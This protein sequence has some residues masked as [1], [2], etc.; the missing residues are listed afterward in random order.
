MP[1]FVEG[2]CQEYARMWWASERASLPPMPAYS[3][4]EKIRREALLDRFQ[5]ALTEERKRP[6]R[7]EADRAAT[8]DRLV[9]AFHRYLRPALDLSDRHGEF[10]LSRGLLE[11]GTAFNHKARRF[12]RGLSSEDVFQAGRNALVMHSIQALLGLPAEVTPAV[13]GYSLLYPYTDNYLDDPTVSGRDKAA[14]NERLARRLAG[15]GP[16]PEGA[17]ERAVWDAVSLIEGQYERKSFPQ[18]FASLQAIHRAQNRSVDLV[19][20][21]ASPYEVDV[22]GICL[23]KGGTSVLADG[24]LVAGSLPKDQASFF[25]GLG[26]YLQLGD[27]LQDVEDNRR[28]GILTV[29]SQT[30]GRW[31]LDAVTKQSLDFCR[32]LLRGADCFGT[33]EAETLKELISL[34]TRL[35]TIEA[36][37]RARKYY[38][39]GFV[40]QLETHFPVRFS[41]LKR[42]QKRATRDR[43]LWAGLL[44]SLL[45]FD[46]QN[47]P[48]QVAVS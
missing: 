16:E 14:F 40:R 31:P 25:F 43:A 12:D 32:N 45:T 15:A 48:N 39:K 5:E 22:L 34:S 7:T 21:G 47:P 19:A 24:Y 44:E 10:L 30:A 35:M 18:V 20:G 8:Q 23:E 11:A 13:L 36:T 9:A 17:H 29:F 46:A 41:Y 28:D 33:P 42:Q 6:P 1:A 2:L 4:A 26:A 3:R 27:D 38:S 37:A